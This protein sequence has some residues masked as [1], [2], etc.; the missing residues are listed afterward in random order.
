MRAVLAL[1][2]RAAAY[3]RDAGADPWDF[4]LRI[5]RLYETGATISD[6]RWLVAKGFAEHGLEMSAC[7]DHHRSFRRSDGLNFEPTTCLV[8]TS[9]GCEFANRI[10]SAATPQ[11]SRSIYTALIA[12]DTTQAPPS[13]LP[14]G[15]ETD[16]PPAAVKP[17][18]DSTRRE[19]TLADTLV[20]RFRVPARNQEIILGVFEEEGWPE[21]IDDPLPVSAGIDAQTRLH[22]VINRLNG[23]QTNRLLRFHGN[24]NGTGV[25]WEL[26]DSDLPPE[27]REATGVDLVLLNSSQNN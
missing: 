6:L 13:D 12:S 27:A 25:S 11:S 8:L 26:R 15:G 9:S 20:K 7:G 16:D 1:L 14:I 4:A 19:L 17:R 21:H 5:D 18:W 3:A 23:K 22:D 24:G 2:W 10:Q